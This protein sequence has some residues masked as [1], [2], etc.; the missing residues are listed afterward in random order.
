ML[1]CFLMFDNTAQLCSEDIA[2][3]LQL[4]RFNSGRHPDRGSTELPRGRR[5]RHGM[6]AEGV[7]RTLSRHGR[8]WGSLG[9]SCWLHTTQSGVLLTSMAF[10][11]LSWLFQIRIKA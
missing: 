9:S 10:F 8:P 7:A 3:P 1:G 5:A 11:C 4:L 2:L 6:Q